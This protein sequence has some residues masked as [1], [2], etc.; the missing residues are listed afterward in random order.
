[1]ND[2]LLAMYMQS[3]E[4]R[5]RAERMKKRIVLRAKAGKKEP[6]FDEIAKYLRVPVEVVIASF[7]QA[8]ARAGMPVVPVGRLH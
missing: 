1:M 6:T 4:Y 2:E 5:R 3:P 7:Q 8:M